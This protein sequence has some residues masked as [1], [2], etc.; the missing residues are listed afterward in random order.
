M[1]SLEERTNKVEDKEHLLL[2][3]NEGNQPVPHQVK[4][5]ADLGFIGASSILTSNF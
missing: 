5:A 4:Q 2:S 1:E 3:F